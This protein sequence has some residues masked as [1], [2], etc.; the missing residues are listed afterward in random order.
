[1]TSGLS[2]SPAELASRILTGHCVRSCWI[3]WRQTVG[4]AQKVVISCATRSL[5][6]AR[7]SKRLLSATI[8]AP[9]FQG[10]KKLDQACLAQPGEEILRWRSP[11]FKPSPN[12][13]DK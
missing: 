2:G 4:G 3:R 6:V 10:A 1:M 5:S 12:I 8:A 11:G 7:A 9:A 13:V